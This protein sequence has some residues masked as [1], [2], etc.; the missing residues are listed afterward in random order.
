MWSA[1]DILKEDSKVKDL[2][3][4]KDDFIETC[5]NLMMS[6]RMKEIMQKGENDCFTPDF[7]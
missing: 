5:Y 4:L 2:A 3:T 1:T 7:I 6:S